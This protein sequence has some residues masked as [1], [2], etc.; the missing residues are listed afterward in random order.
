[1][2]LL[3]SAAAVAPAFAQQPNPLE[4]VRR[5][6]ERNAAA[7]VLE[8]RDLLA[9]PNVA[10]DRDN[11]RR[12]AQA[13]VAMLQKRGVTARIIETGGPPI[14]YGEV[15]DAS[16]PTILFYCHYDGQPV[17]PSRWSQANPWTP[18]LRTG[19][20]EHGKVM[21]Q[22][23]QPGSRID[24]EWRIFARS[25]S[26]D[27]APII[28]LMAMLDAWREQRVP[29]RNRIKFLF[30]GDEEAGSA[31][32]ADVVRRNRAL[33]AADLVVMAD[34]PIHPSNRPTADF[35][36][37][38]NVGVTLTM[39]G[40]IAPLHS[41]HYGN[42]APNPA[43][44]LAQLLATMKG[45]NG[46]V[47][48]AGWDDDVTPPGPAEREAWARYPHDDEQRR[49]QLQL[50]SLDGG[51]KT[52][53]ELIARPSLNIRGLQSLFTG[54]QART[55]VPDV[56]IAELDLRLVAGNDPRRQVDKLVRHIQR[57]G[58]TVVTQEP[59]SAVRVNT[60]RLIR[61]SANTGYP[62][63]RTPLANPVARAL[64]ASLS[65]AGLGEPVVSPTMGGSGPAY[66][67]TDILRAP[68][69][70]LPTVNHDNNQHAENENL[71]L[72]NLFTGAVI[73]AA[74]AVSVLKPLQ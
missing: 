49:L 3:C 44:R 48:V 29:L 70:A 37:R 64:V 4:A 40:A 58:Y 41:G 17:E 5:Y 1:L 8:L 32:L 38:G 68:F 33:L 43:M 14:V 36:L 23:P 24:P 20:L 26:D 72:G 73:L 60:P 57:Q 35:G 74:A 22:W 6:T 2:P 67:F 19:T 54:A 11:I 28:A 13:L 65:A 56:A 34:G 53:L 31:Y 30:E 51:G 52:R 27:K 46:E 55:L 45:P 69:V 59:D 66:V 7:I 39:Y 12:N 50:G 18:V 9:I 71:R 63:G 15:G 42:W 47:L 21:E 61:V 25:A 10:A 62:A 16:L